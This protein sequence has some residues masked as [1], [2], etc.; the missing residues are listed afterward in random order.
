MTDVKQLITEH[1]DIWLTA[2]TEKK[3][4]RGRS[5]GASSSIYG[6]QKLRELILELAVLGKLTTQ[7][8]NEDAHQEFVELY[9]D[10][11]KLQKQQNFKTLDNKPT[12]IEL[13]FEIPKNWHICVFD[14]IA[15]I[16]RGGSPRPIKSFLTDENDPDGVNWIKIGDSER[17]TIYINS[18]SEKIKAAGVSSSRMV[19]PDDLIL[20]NSMSFGY[21]YIM[22]IE[23]CIHDGWLVI[24]TPKDKINKLFLYYLLRS[25][26][27]RKQFTKAAAG[28][29]VQNLNAD[30]VKEL[31]LPLPPLKEQQRIVA[32]VDELMQLC[33][34]LEQQQNLSTEAHEQLV[35]VLLNA[36]TNSANADEFQQNWQRISANFDLLFT[37]DYSI[38]QLKQT[39]LQ[40]A[41]MGKLVKQDP[42]DEPASEL[43]KQIAEEKAKLVKEG[44]IKKS[45]P[46]PEIT[47]DEK[48]F[49]LPSGWAWTPLENISSLITKGSSPKWQGVNYVNEGILFI[50]SE[51]VGSYSLILDNL[52]YVEE[53]FNQIE[54]RSILEK[55]DFL[56]NIVGGS[57]GRTAIYDL[58]EVSNI[59]QA[60]CL[61]RLFLEY[62][63]KEFILHFFNSQI[64]KYY[65]FDKQVD[66]ARPNLSMGNI[67]KFIIPIPPMLEQKRIVGKVNQL[68]SIIDQL[69]VL[70]AK[71]RQTQLHLA[72]VLVANAVEGA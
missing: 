33:D 58:D 23:G 1:L 50:T 8:P 49:E 70:Q 37:T 64:C 14:E 30:K 63:D 15:A 47:D 12:N 5:S 41:V 19:Y 20:S 17:G 7:D 40:L 57:I 31:V 26:Y 62:L 32:K 18:T 36:L 29:V 34:Q 43:L 69:R 66:N 9:K 51:N 65:M 21:P 39:V 53:K 13:G 38:E 4:G 72:D 27:A 68:F 6:V 52:K 22:N 45:K 59:N 71:A 35:D 2:E 46:L 25:P 56:M 60:V 3:S 48:P 44:K 55:N 10:A 16:A 28:A 67:A 42:S 24:R 61:I 54:P 11:I